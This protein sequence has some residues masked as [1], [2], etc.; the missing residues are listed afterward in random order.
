MYEPNVV[1]DWHEYDEHAG[2]RVRVH[3][4]E[5]AEPPRGRDEAAEGLTYFCLR[6]TVENRG[7]RSCCVHLEDGQIDVRLGADGE[8]AFV[9]WRNSQFVEGFD[10]YPLRRVTAVLYAAGPEAALDL[11]DVQVQLR[12]D[13]E[14]AGRRMWVGGVGLHDGP[15]E[16]AAA[17]GRDSLAR[18]VSNFLRDQ[19]EEGTA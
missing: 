10:V 2:L 11:V 16:T 18:Q 13:E 5:R 15:A 3:R 6:V 12:A 9:D 19:A 17:T 7:E 8:S 1:G 14:W 4:L